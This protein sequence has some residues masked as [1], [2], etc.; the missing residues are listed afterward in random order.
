[1]LNQEQGY[2]ENRNDFQEIN[3]NI[4]KMGFYS[5]PPEKNQVED[6]EEKIPFY[7]K[8]IMFACGFSYG[9]F[10]L[11][12]VIFL[13][14]TGKTKTE[15]ITIGDEVFVISGVYFTLFAI[16]L[17]FIFT[18]RKYFASKLKNPS[19]YLKGLIFGVV[20]IGIEMGVGMIMNTIL[21]AETNA[22][23]QTIIDYTQ[24]Y[25]ILMFIVT[26][27]IGPLCEEMTYRVG[28]FEAIKEK[29]E[30]VALIATSLIFAAIHISFQDTTARAELNALP[31][32]M[33]IGFCLTYCYKKYG[34]AASYVAH[35]LLNLLSFL[36]I[37]SQI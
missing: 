21:P 17:F 29:N 30:T 7:V 19:L 26:V 3:T 11:L 18:Y 23:Q 12:N 36:A 27:F 35:V 14:F 28:L 1:M 16:F 10:F 25:P 6:N 13:L 2:E 31:V 4:E 24:A 37:L 9:G 20:T 15:D 5:I 32:Y 33:A 8:I 34:L 22:N